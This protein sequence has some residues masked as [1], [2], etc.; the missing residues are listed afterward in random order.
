MTTRPNLIIAL[1]ISA[2][3]SAIILANWVPA[4]AGGHH[5]TMG[6]S[7]H[8]S[9][10]QGMM[11]HAPSLTK[12]SMYDVKINTG[13]SSSGFGILG[14]VKS[15]G[16]MQHNFL[17]GGTAVT[18]PGKQLETNTDTARDRRKEALDNIQK[19]LDIIHGMQPSL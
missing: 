18:K 3:V 7:S 12:S 17:Q 13:H 10:Q 2:A 8:M 19:T 11:S 16:T 15:G 5:G 14:Q 4:Q 1:V 6:P 9:N